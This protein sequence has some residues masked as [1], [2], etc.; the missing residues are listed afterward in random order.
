MKERQEAVAEAKNAHYAGMVLGTP[1]FGMVSWNF[2][3]NMNTKGMPIFTNAG[4]HG[5]QGKPVD[6]ARNEIAWAAIQNKN[7]Y[8]LFR[9]DDTLAPHDAVPKLEGR[10]PKSEKA[11]PYEKGNTIV[12]G[13]VY[14]K[15]EPPV[16]MVH[17]E[18]S[19]A[20]YQD[21]EFGD[22]VEC[23]AVGMGCTLIPVGVFRKALAYVKYYHCYNMN[24]EINWS[25][26]PYTI[27]G[28]IS[29][30]HG[31]E[32]TYDKAGECPSCQNVLAPVFFRTLRIEDDKTGA[33][34]SGAIMTEDAYFCRMAKKAG[35]KIF[36]DAAVLCDHEIFHPDPRQTK[37]YCFHPGIGPAWK[38][39]GGVYYYPPTDH[40]TDIR[41]L[42]KNGKKKNGKVRFN[43]GSGTVNKK[44]YINIDL[45]TESDFKCDARNLSPVI[46]KYGQADE[47]SADHLLE[48]M[49][50]GEL[51]GV[52]RHW[53]RC[54]KP[55]G[56][57]KIVCPDGVWAAENFVKHAKNGDAPND[58][59][60]MV[61]MGRQHYPGDDHRSLIY[62]KRLHGI[63][64]ACKDQVKSYT[65]RTVFPKSHN[66]Q[67]I[68]LRVI[69]KA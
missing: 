34:G 16:P 27:D 5:V 42:I 15:V 63:M 53:L 52:M 28:V 44:G 10:I 51:I 7:S 56:V 24:C 11:C 20:G 35:C 18:G 33:E 55:N 60:E 1:T 9:D 54:L 38:M 29:K 26:I 25:G 46:K 41:K 32:V 8:V 22:L 40:K 58:F 36:A 45:N 67:I 13:I 23:D 6:V 17:R 50:I 30:T 21:W 69:K 19:T 31:I 2:L 57:L 39:N 61:V 48:H 64:A 59:P 47:I 3:T 12:A 49:G 14:S 62:E 66:Q 65:L 43:L 68:R 4:Y 37:H